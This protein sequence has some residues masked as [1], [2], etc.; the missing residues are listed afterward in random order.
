MELSTH[1]LFD[2]DC[3]EAFRFYELL[4]GGEIVTLLSY[5]DSPMAGDV[6]ETWR[7]KIVH[8]TMLL[9]GRTLSGADAPP[10][11]YQRPQGFA[12]L[13]H[14]STRESCERLFSTLAEGGAVKIPLQET[15][16]SPAYGMVIDRFGIP[17]EVSCDGASGQESAP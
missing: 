9:D 15:F 12:V 5:G 17:W 8:A 3:E 1:L 2:G 13:V 7:S 14:P 11:T 6:P 10:D 16:W 4:L